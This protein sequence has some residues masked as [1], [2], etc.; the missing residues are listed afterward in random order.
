MEE[1]LFL[2]ITNQIRDRHHKSPVYDT[3]TGVDAVHE[4][5]DQEVIEKDTHELQEFRVIYDIFLS[6]TYQVP[7]LYVRIQNPSDPFHEFDPS[8]L[9]LPDLL[10][11]QV[12]HVGVL[13][14]IS[15]TVNMSRSPLHKEL[16]R[17]GPS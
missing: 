3:S 5:D 6:P 15:M 14:A 10:H 1:H 16:T 11:P 13:G 17:V 2:R 7:V 4:D 9:L 12:R 8:Q